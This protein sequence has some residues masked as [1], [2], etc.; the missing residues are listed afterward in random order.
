[1]GET[2]HD[3]AKG[4][5]PAEAFRAGR[6]SL[7]G[8][9]EATRAA[10]PAAV[11]SAL[12]ARALGAVA[13][14]TGPLPFGK[15]NRVF[16]V[17]VEG[18]GAVVVKVFAYEDWPEGGKPEWL[19]E[20]LARA[21]VPHARLLHCSRG[22][23]HFPAGFAVY[24]HVEGRNCVEAM[25]AGTLSGREYCRLVG[26]YLRAVHSVGLAGYGYVNDGAGTDDD[27]VECKLV[28]DVSDRLLEVDERLHARLFPVIEEEVT[29]LLRPLEGRFTPRL[30]HGDPFPRNA[31][32]TAPGE[33][34]FVDWDEAM[35]GIWPEDLARLSYWFAHENPSRVC[36]RL[37]GAEVAEAFLRGYGESEFG[38][39]E[40][41]RI[42]RA[43][44]VVYSADLIS[45][46]LKTNNTESC[47]RT[48]R[49]LEELLKL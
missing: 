33:L 49:V 28:Y 45:Y 38:A 3:S 14:V 4:R 41:A 42:E 37:T 11:E 18:G 15:V 35:S 5:D 29:R 10:I 19:E 26:A 34:L 44:H 12:G 20:Q 7:T 8:D 2:G 39:D 43:L 46:Q 21:A 30:L 17:E 16:K 13:L 40:L 48:M 25:R 31:L 47:R 6:S 24:E 1:M 27:Y 36:E 22:K 23:E 9:E 32:L